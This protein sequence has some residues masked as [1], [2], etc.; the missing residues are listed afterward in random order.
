M[1]QNSACPLCG[2]SAFSF[3]TIAG[4]G[5]LR[6]GACTLVFLDPL[7]DPGELKSL[8]RGA[9]AKLLGIPA[10]REEELFLKMGPK[11]EEGASLLDIGSSGG[12]F[13]LEAQ[14]RGFAAEGVELREEGRGASPPLPVFYG[15]FEEYPPGRT[16]SFITMLHTLEHFPDPVAMV[17]KAKSLLSPGGSLL[18]TVPNFGSAAAGVLG[19]YW[20]WFQPPFHLFHFNA[21]TM[22]LLLEKCGLEICEISS[23]RS[24]SLSLATQLSFY[25][26][27]V[28]LKMSG[29]YYRARTRVTGGSGRGKA[30]LVALLQ[31]YLKG[32]DVLMAP[33]DLLLTP[34]SRHLEKSLKGEELVIVARHCSGK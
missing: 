8:Y 11:P 26:P 32:A 22:A 24:F 28:L 30:P 10:R 33:M 16:F 15:P 13:L 3:C 19:K 14:R 12:H 29:I 21:R 31:A 18:I 1:P 20:E 34:L 27:I 6:C 4:S 17:S 5:Y 23:R 7:P 2:G 25:L 9:Y